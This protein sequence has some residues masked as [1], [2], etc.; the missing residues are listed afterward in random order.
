M[1][2]YLSLN[3]SSLPKYSLGTSLAG[4]LEYTCE[5]TFWKGELSFMYEPGPKLGAARS[6]GEVLL[7]Y[8]FFKKEGVGSKNLS[9]FF[10]PPRA[11]IK[12]LF[13]APPVIY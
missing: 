13:G 5:R 8:A 10:G 6:K 11:R 2:A 1:S 9:D 3:L 7:V 12:K 4:A